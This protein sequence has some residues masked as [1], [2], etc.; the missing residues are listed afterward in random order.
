MWKIPWKEELGGGVA[1]ELNMTGHAH[2]HICTHTHTHT[3][4]HTRGEAGKG[5][6]PLLPQVISCLNSFWPKSTGSQRQESSCGL[7][8]I[9]INLPGQKAKWRKGRSRIWGRGAQ[10]EANGTLAR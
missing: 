9:E 5:N 4:T 7:Q 6:L 8:S 2:V 3:H 10:L 1:E